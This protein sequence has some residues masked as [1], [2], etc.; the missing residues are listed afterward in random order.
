MP[1]DADESVLLDVLDLSGD[2]KAKS[3][4][5]EDYLDDTCPYRAGTGG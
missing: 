5:F 4:A 3:M 1:D 2:E